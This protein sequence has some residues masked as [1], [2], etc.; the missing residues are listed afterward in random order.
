MQQVARVPEKIAGHQWIFIFYE[1]LRGIRNSSHSISPGECL[2]F[3]G[4][5]RK[6]VCR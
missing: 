6:L 2:P 5:I 1:M 3:A 4:S